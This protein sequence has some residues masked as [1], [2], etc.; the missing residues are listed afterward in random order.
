MKQEK[1]DELVKGNIF[2][3]SNTR[4][5][6]VFCTWSKCYDVVNL[7]CGGISFILIGEY[8]PPIHRR[9]DI[10]ANMT[11]LERLFLIWISSD[12]VVSFPQGQTSPCF[13]T[14]KLRHQFRYAG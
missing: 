4:A 6:P 8:K 14:I 1:R 11:R 12:F 9:Y 2:E 7:L 13:Y 3:E 5:R 10:D